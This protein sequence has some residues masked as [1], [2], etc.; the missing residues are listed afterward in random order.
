MSDEIEFAKSMASTHPKL[1]LEYLGDASLI[2]AGTNKKLHW[3][4]RKCDHEWMATG[5]DRYRVDGK[6]TGCPACVNKV[7]HMDGRN[8]MAVTNPEM[9]IEFNGDPHK[10]ITGKFKKH[11]WKCKSCHHIWQTTGKTYLSKGCPKCNSLG[12]KYP[13]LAKEWHPDNNN[14]PFD[15]ASRSNQEVR[16]KCN[17]GHEWNSK[18]SIRSM[19]GGRKCPYCANQAVS[20]DNNLQINNPSLAKEWHP[21]KNGKLTPSDVVTK[22]AKKVWWKCDV[23]DDHEWQSTPGQRIGTGRGCP[24]CSGQKVSKT[25]QLDLKYPD[26][27]NEWN[28]EKNQKKASEYH[29]GSNAKVWWIC[30]TCE[31]EWEATISNRTRNKSN[32]PSCL[33]MVVHSNGGNSLGDLSEIAKIQWDYEKNSN[34]SPYN[35]RPSSKIRVWWKC[36]VCQNEWQ[37]SINGRFD[38]AGNCHKGCNVC[39]SKTVS[40]KLRMDKKE[41]IDKAKKIHNGKYDYDWKDLEYENTK[42]IAPIICPIHGEFFQVIAVH[43]YGPSGCTI[44]AKEAGW[45]GYNPSK[46]G[47]YYVNEIVNQFGDR[48]YFKAG[49]SNQWK[50]RLKQLQNGIP[51]NLRIENLEVI[52]FG[53]GIEA[54]KLEQKILKISRN[55]NWKAPNRDFDGG[56]ELFLFNPISYARENGLI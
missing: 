55:E 19:N 52:E 16:W 56:S 35:F 21:T 33:G 47:Y 51:P 2:K 25:N 29:F 28:S 24:Y 45:G 27:S 36:E 22:S 17:N 15:Y 4:C 20:I 46:I 10:V 3:K 13:H 53:K 44:C 14:S 23:A 40:E 9:I 43:L 12:G 54:L 31:H 50:K 5:Y 34:L 48:L 49:I 18:I 30:S 42:Q 11:E 39:A 7:V 8:S 41:V 37:T 38:R 1:S 26:I 32:C 6:N